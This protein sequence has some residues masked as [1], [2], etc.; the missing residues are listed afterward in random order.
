MKKLLV[1]LLSMLMVLSMVPA[2]AFAE[3]A[4][5][6]YIGNSRLTDGQGTNYGEGTATLNTAE[7]TLT[8]KDVT[9][10]D[11]I[12]I[13]AE[14]EFTVIVEGNCTIGSES[15]PLTA[16]GIYAIDVTNL[17]IKMA[18]GS[19]LA[20]YNE[21]GNNIFSSGNL[22]VSGQGTLKAVAESYPSLYA[23]KNLTLESG[24]TA[25]IESA[26]HGLCV[27]QGQVLVDGA[28]VDINAGGCGIFVNYFY[29]EDTGEEFPSSVIL[30]NSDLTIT[31]EYM[32]GVYAGG[33]V[34]V[35][36]TRLTVT[37]TD[38]TVDE[39]L[40]SEG[41]TIYSNG[42][43]TISGDNTVIKTDDASGISG[44]WVE[45]LGGTLNL[46]SVQDALY[47]YGGL[48]VSGG[49]IDAESTEGSALATYTGELKLTGNAEIT[50]TSHSEDY[51]AIGN[52]RGG[53]IVL[54]AKVTAVNNAENGLPVLGLKQTDSVG[55]TIGEGFETDGVKVYQETEKDEHGCWRTYFVSASDE[56]NTPFTG[57]TLTV[58][59]P[60]SPE[61]TYPPV[62]VVQRPTIETDGNA[63]AALNSTGTR[64]TIT[65]ADGYEIAD[66]TLN[67][68][69][70]GKVT[71]V[72]NLK[73][74]DIVV[75]TTKKIQT[76]EDLKAEV[77]SLKLV[78][79]STNEKA[80]SGKKA[81]KV[82]WFE[83]NGKELNLD[84]YEIYRSTKKNS[85]YGTKPIYKTTK[86]LQYFNTSAK[87]GTR[88]YYK[89]RG[90]KMIEGEKI[91]TDYSL[92]AIRTAK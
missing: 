60:S 52:I 68:Q 88:Y 34:T 40:G 69:S 8:L 83:K 10:T 48:I 30:R 54:D 72:T 45:I 22:T 20:V 33:D 85:G 4:T 59:E 71:E 89:V 39:E 46:K 65:A 78:A 56:T 27:N 15:A 1:L 28:K 37:V 18:E 7:K 91:Y 67:G 16:S 6:V 77:K 76:T 82:Y 81:I 43:L 84:G 79:R 49:K 61:P 92:K 31:T 17:H 86:S 38:K 5:Q 80:P 70:L 42:N 58:A 32:Q 90:Y 74:G 64:V 73:T 3:T 24:V 35:D 75:V 21:E 47:G 55:I 53:G 12:G 14:G 50:A 87:K 66:V 62:L 29:D 26:W 23:E 41:F 44:E 57:G 13:Y 63:A 25:D 11:S 36:N 2:M 19:T 9:L 51:A